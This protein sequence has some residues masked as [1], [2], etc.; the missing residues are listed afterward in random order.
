MCYATLT[1]PQRAH[2]VTMSLLYNAAPTL[3]HRPQCT[4]SPTM[5]HATHNVQATHNCS[6]KPQCA[7]RRNCATIPTV[8]H[9]VLS[10]PQRPLSL[11][12][13]TLI[14]SR[15]VHCATPSYLFAT[16]PTLCQDVRIVPQ[17]PHLLCHTALTVPHLP[18]YFTPS[19]LFL[20]ALSVSRRPHCFTPP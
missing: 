12:H 11:Y 2:Y 9:I 3:P 19:S 5:C 17:R 6:H 4:T 18:Q 16:K 14:V 20:A 1:M 8:W 15:R 10:V 7:S 13:A